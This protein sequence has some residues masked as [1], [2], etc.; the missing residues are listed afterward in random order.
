MNTS[1]H[2][3][4]EPGLQQLL[5]AYADRFND[6]FPVFLMRGTAEADL[7]T[8][9]KDCLDQ[10]KPYAVDFDNDPGIDY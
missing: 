8:L 4:H 1:N 5:I 10:G 7:I 3:T 6:S 9:I 2:Q